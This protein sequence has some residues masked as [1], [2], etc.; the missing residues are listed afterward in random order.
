MT[1]L[2]HNFPKGPTGE[3]PNILDRDARRRFIEKGNQLIL[4]ESFFSVEELFDKIQTENYPSSIPKNALFILF[5]RVLEEISSEEKYMRMS[6]LAEDSEQEALKYLSTVG[7]V[8]V[9]AKSC[10]VTQDAV[11]FIRRFVDKIEITAPVVNF[12]K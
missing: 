8:V 9:D 7:Y 6:R 5:L 11:N 12:K 3:Y 4:L 2:K 1:E 10:N